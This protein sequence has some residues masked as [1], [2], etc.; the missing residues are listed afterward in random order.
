[1][2]SYKVASNVMMVIQLMEMDV[3]AFAQ[4][5][6][7]LKNVEMEPYKEHKVRYV[8]MVIQ[9]METDVIVVAKF[10]LDGFVIF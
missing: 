10:N 5:K 8:M 6:F 9:L 1:M 3:I 7:Q 2:E 4:L